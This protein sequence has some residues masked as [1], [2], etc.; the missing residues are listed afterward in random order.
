MVIPDFGDGE[1]E[2][3]RQEAIIVRT[4]ESG[5]EILGGG[6]GAGEYAWRLAPTG[7]SARRETDVV[8]GLGGIGGAGPVLS[9]KMREGEMANC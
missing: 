6:V 9:E 7:S 2:R 5:D 8:S 1:P 3:V 4:W